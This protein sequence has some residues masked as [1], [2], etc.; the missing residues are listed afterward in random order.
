[1]GVK[2][3]DMWFSG[4]MKRGHIAL[5]SGQ[6][7]AVAIVTSATKKGVAYTNH[8]DKKQPVNSLAPRVPDPLTMNYRFKMTVGRIV[9]IGESPYK[10]DL[11]QM[12]FKRR[13]I[14]LPPA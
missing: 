13:D 2:G 14:G 12:S 3:D 11:S 7:T 4:L 9:R 8:L 10:D 1:M 5:V 6:F